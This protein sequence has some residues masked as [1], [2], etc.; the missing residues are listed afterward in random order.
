[1][2]RTIRFRHLIHTALLGAVACAAQSAEFVYQGRLD[3]RG[4][5]ANGRYDLRLAAYGDEKSASGLMAPIEFPGVEVRDGR[6]ELRFEAP[7]AK[8]REA[9]LEVAVRDVGAGNFATIP[10]RSKAISAPLIGTCWSSTGD[11]GSNPATN[12]LGTTDVQSLVLRTGN[13]P[14]LRI[15][16]ASIL[17]GGLPITASLVVGS[18]LNQARAGVRGAVIAGGGVISGND[19]EWPL[20]PNRVSDHYGTVGGGAGNIAGDDAGTLKDRALATVGG[21]ALNRASGQL[22]TVGGGSGNTAD[23]SLSWIGG[24]DGNVASG[25]YSSIGAGQQNVAS[26]ERSTVAGG[27]KNA[28]TGDQASVGGGWFNLASGESSSIAGGYENTGGGDRSTIAGGFGNLAGD[29]FS[30][31]GGGTWNAAV[32][33]YAVVPGGRANCAGGAHALA[34]GN[35]AKVRP[36]NDP[37]SGS[38]A[39]LSYPGGEGDAG[40]FVWADHQ[41]AN[42]VSTGP[43]QFL[44]RAAGGVALNTNTLAAGTDLAVASRSAGA[45]VDVLLRRTVPRGASTWL[46]PVTPPVLGCTSRAATA[47]ATSTT[48]CGRPTG[49]C[50][51]STTTR[52]SPPR[53]DGRRLPT[54]A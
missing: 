27:Y 52:S 19:P 37:G 45:N 8:E 46:R 30:T 31:V 40:T 35:Q 18:H 34:A 2:S 11:S 7:L 22:S 4:A 23:G 39:G 48:R 47:A 20:S 49:A 21:G 54:N 28:A 12:F 29:V 5:P 42:F 6:F 51:C 36:A 3:D 25:W 41:L 26:G 15:E 24:G 43:D 33:E 38:C 16:P 50:G 53:A 9:W 32:A 14:S 1:M 44:V 13:A 10:G 17:T